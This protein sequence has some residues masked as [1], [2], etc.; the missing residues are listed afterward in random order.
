V[1]DPV[2]H[3]LIHAE[4]PGGHPVR[5]PLPAENEEVHRGPHSGPVNGTGLSGAENQLTKA[6]RQPLREDDIISLTVD[7]KTR[8]MT[9]NLTKQ[10]FRIVLKTSLHDGHT[11]PFPY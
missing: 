9:V 4:R 6:A 7:S 3:A 10:D 1:T 2:D 5:T 11:S 8:Q